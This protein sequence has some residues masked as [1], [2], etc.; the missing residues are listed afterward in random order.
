MNPFGP[1]GP[2][3]VGNV[4]LRPAI[5]YGVVEAQ[6]QGELTRKLLSGDALFEALNQ[7]VDHLK[8]SAPAEHDVLVIAFGINVTKVGF[9]EP[10]AFLLRGYD[11]DGNDTYVVAHFSQL[12][13]QVIYLPKKGPDRVITG[14][15]RVPA[16]PTNQAPD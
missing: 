12:V 4:D 6:R 8:S 11:N 13:T 10:H 2:S 1:H 9:I 15:A 14:F 16:E 5:N 3:L 7:A